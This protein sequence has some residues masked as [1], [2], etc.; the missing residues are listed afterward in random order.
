MRYGRR[1][2]EWAEYP[3][4]GRTV[5]FGSEHCLKSSN[6]ILIATFTPTG[7]FG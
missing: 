6:R 4:D 1:F 3:I 5:R 7:G 2:R